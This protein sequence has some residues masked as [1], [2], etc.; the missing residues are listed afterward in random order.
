MYFQ[1]IF[2]THERS[3]R[4]ARRAQICQ[5]HLIFQLSKETFI[6]L[7]NAIVLCHPDII[8]HSRP[9]S[10]NTSPGLIPTQ[11]R[12]NPENTTFKTICN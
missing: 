5:C 8:P 9:P 11:V 4:I 12:W 1:D 10:R 6:Q 7:N 3:D 2:F